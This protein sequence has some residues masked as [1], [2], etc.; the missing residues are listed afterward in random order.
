MELAVITQNVSLFSIH[1]YIWVLGTWFFGYICGKEISPPFMFH[2]V[3]A[4]PKILN[5]YFPVTPL[6]LSLVLNVYVA[7]VIS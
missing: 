5:A 3:H 1:F 2:T 7:V 6:E 4:P